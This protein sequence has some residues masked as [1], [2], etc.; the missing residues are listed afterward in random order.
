MININDEF[1]LELKSIIKVK[2]V[3]DVL[4][5]IFKSMSY[6]QN[7]SYNKYLIFDILKNIDVD[8]YDE[9]VLIEFLT[10][11]HY[12]NYN[13]DNNIFYYRVKKHLA[14]LYG[15]KETNYILWGLKA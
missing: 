10:V 15:E 2:S 11:I 12:F 13:L 8:K 6:F 3:D 7:F 4:D 9:S 14:S 5:Y 1:I